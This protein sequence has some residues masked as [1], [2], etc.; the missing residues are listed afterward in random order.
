VTLTAP[1]EPEEPCHIVRIPYIYHKD[2][3]TNNTKLRPKRAP[4]FAFS[5]SQTG[6]NYIHMRATGQWHMARVA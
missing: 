1:A 6:P 4:A 3:Y 5:R 2:E